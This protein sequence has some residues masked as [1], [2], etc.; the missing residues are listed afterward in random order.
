M[1]KD[2]KPYTLRSVHSRAGTVDG[3]LYVFHNIAPKD[4]SIPKTSIKTPMRIMDFEKRKMFIPQ[5]LNDD[6]TGN[7]RGEEDEKK[8]TYLPIDYRINYSLCAFKNR[9]W[10][11]GGL[12]QKNEVLTTMES[13]DTAILKFQTQ[14]F[15]GDVKP[16][17]RQG[18]QAVIMNQY[19]MFIVGGTYS[20]KLIDPTPIPEH[21]SMWSYD[22]ESGHWQKF[23]ANNTYV[24]QNAD[25]LEKVSVEKIKGADVMPWNLVHHHAFKVDND[26]VGV[27]WFDSHALNLQG[28]DIQVDKPL[29]KRT[30]MVS[31]FNFAKSHWKNL[32]V[33]CIPLDE[34]EDTGSGNLNGIPTVDFEYRFGASIYPIFDVEC[35]RVSRVLLFGGMDLRKPFGPTKQEEAESKGERSLP[36]AQFDFIQNTFPEIFD[37][38]PAAQLQAEKTEPILGSA[39]TEGQDAA[40][41]TSKQTKA[42]KV[43]KKFT[44][45]E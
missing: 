39:G 34:S 28:K 3:R 42:P 41:P 7:K 11:Y 15:R 9:L 30:T 20:D 1:I 18:H 22:L 21:D 44:E 26:N 13:F 4:E 45:D 27:I 23:R 38:K 24:N 14:K 10:M 16:A 36:F 37:I 19:A 5:F 40:E 6:S 43:L 35:D 2:T 17:G 33:A 29:N 12:N 31:L 32:K 8:D 25:I